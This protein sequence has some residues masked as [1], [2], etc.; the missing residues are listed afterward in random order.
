M[1]DL[2]RVTQ[3]M[4][5]LYDRFTHEGDMSRRDMM[6][7]MSRLAGSAA[8]AAAIV[9]LIEASAQAAAPPGTQNNQILAQRIVYSDGINER[10]AGWLAHPER[11]QK[12]MPRVLVIHENRGL[13]QHIKDVT[14]RLAA[15]GFVALAPDFLSSVGETPTSGDGTRTADDIARE[16]IGT[17]DPKRVIREAKMSMEFL[18][19]HEHGLGVPGAVGFCWGGL[20]VNELAMAA[21]KKLRAGVVYYGMAPKDM[22]GA[23]NIKARM[24]LHYAGLDERVN[25]TA[26]AWQAALKAAGVDFA[27]FT[28]PNVNHAFNNDTSAARYNTDAAGLAWARTLAW[29]AI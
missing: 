15:A 5:A 3:E 21:G 10:M 6:A 7:G 26:E 16:R 2:T 12:R 29:L 1:T 20:M 14:T 19:E 28:Y 8:A 22:S 25:A 4:I 9:P 18:A 24:L 23:R 13:N 17:L 11:G 27:A